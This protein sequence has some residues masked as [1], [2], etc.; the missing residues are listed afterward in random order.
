M[1][2]HFFNVTYPSLTEG[3]FPAGKLKKCKDTPYSIFKRTNLSYHNV[4][5]KSI[6]N[7]SVL[8]R[9]L[10]NQMYITFTQPVP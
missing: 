6:G 4:H 9:L 5:D 3:D 1:F 10:K 7:L 2:S 8:N